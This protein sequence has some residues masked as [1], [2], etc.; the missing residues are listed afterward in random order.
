MRCNALTIFTVLISF[1]VSNVDAIFTDQAYKSDFHVSLLGAPSQRNTFFHRPSTTSKASL[2]YTLSELN[3]LG[4]VNPKD[5]SVVWRQL[6]ASAAGN[7]TTTNG[8]LKATESEVFTTVGNTIGVWDAADGKLVWDWDAS[9]PVIWFDVAKSVDGTVYALGVSSLEGSPNIVTALSA[10]N[11]KIVW[12]YEDT[13]GDFPLAV[14]GSESSVFYVSLHKALIGSSKIAV[15]TLDLSTGRQIAHVSFSADTDDPVVHVASNSKIPVL[16][17]TDRHVK[18]LKI[19]V[20]GSTNVQTATLAGYEKEEVTEIA[21]LS[22]AEIHP[23]TDFLVY[24]QT[25]KSHWAE[26][27]HMDKTGSLYKRHE[28]AVMG[29]KGAF[30]CSIVD[31]IVHFTRNTDFEVSLTSATSPNILAKWPVRPKSHGGAFEPQGI[32]HAV[33]EVVSKGGSNFAIRSAVLVPSGDWI[34]IRNGDADWIRHEGLSG[35]IAAAYVEAQAEEGLAHDLEI[36]SQENPVSAYLHRLTRHIK[37]LQT[38]PS[39]IIKLSTKLLT[40]VIGDRLGLDADATEL[41]TFGFRKLVIVATKQGRVA[42]IDTASEGKVVWSTQVA[43]MTG[44]ESWKIYNINVGTK[45]IGISAGDGAYMQLSIATGEIIK[46]QPGGVVPEVDHFLSVPEDLENSPLILV[47]RDGSVQEAPSKQP[48][49]ADIIVTKRPDNS[50]AGWGLAYRKRSLTWVFRPATGEVIS[51]VTTRPE[52]DP[53]ASIGK[54]LG[55][56]RVLYK[57]LNPNLAVIIAKNSEANTASVYLIDSIS[58]QL[59]FTTKHTGVDPTKPIPVT[60]AQNWFAY[61][62][63]SDPSI[64]YPTNPNVPQLPQPKSYQM[65]ISELYESIHPNDRGPLGSAQNFSSLRFNPE[66]PSSPHVISASY[67]VPGPIT[68][69][70]TTTT[71]QGITPPSILAALPSLNAL[72]AIPLAYLSARRPLNRDPTPQEAE[73]GLMRYHPTLDFSPKWQLNHKREMLGIEGIVTDSTNMESTSLVFAWGETDLFGTRVAGIG[74]FDILGAR[75][76]KLSLMLTVVALALGT[77]VL[78]PMVS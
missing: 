67:I 12:K 43:T 64:P 63:F 45:T 72:I 2:L 3:V 25:P 26:V 50:V 21:V 14:I 60:F 75:F 62:L 4:A 33:S 8:V 28:L 9:G 39:A 77:G 40:S 52:H 41:T 61:S 17:W 47:G 65:A 51:S 76:G 53:V 7:T 18:I 6:L 16:V 70:T 48:F 73:E 27:F 36:E 29:G 56:R 34:M 37:Q 1:L 10:T 19:N 42:A 31:D 22:P 5:G 23:Q 59:L 55:D 58:G 38:V 49:S 24:F 11:G 32:T 35:I 78:A 15:T 30:S 13:S 68:H 71:L 20:L 54:A 44:G 69:L 46:Q 74:E 66:H 57:Y